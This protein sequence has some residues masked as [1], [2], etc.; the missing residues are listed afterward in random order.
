MGFAGATVDYSHGSD[1]ILVVFTESLDL[2]SIPS[3]EEFSVTVN[4]DPAPVVVEVPISD[5]G[6]GL[7]DLVLSEPLAGTETVLVS[8]TPIGPPITGRYTGQVVDAFVDAPVE[9][10]LPQN[11]TSGTIA[12]GG[13]LTTLS[14]GGPTVSDPLATTVMVPVGGA[15]SITEQP[16]TSQTS[17]GYTFFGQEVLITA[18]PAADAANP[19]L[20][21]FDLHGTLVPDGESGETI[22]ILR[23]DVV[24]PQCS[25][26]APAAARA[27]PSPCVWQRVDQPDGSVSITVATVA[28]SRWNF[29]RMNPFSFVGFGPPVNDAPM[30]NG[31]K[32]GAAVP[33]KFSLG[34]DRGLAIFAEGSPSSQ[35]VSCDTSTPYDA[36]EQTVT[37]GNSALSYNASSDSYTYVWKTSS[38]WSGCRKLTLAFADGSVEEAIFQFRH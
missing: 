5:I 23:N 37:A 13:L 6:I 32:A 29:G 12:P 35:A 20:V 15:A 16:L 8:Y 25:N 7:I 24:V 3:A 26:P 38:A 21:T 14:D 22:D 11:A 4:G 33:L 18:P 36:V 19:L 27:I 17:T 10:F 31:I 28:A 9:Y 1:R 2:G 34:G 30:R